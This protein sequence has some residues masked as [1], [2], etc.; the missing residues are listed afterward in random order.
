[1]AIL[2]GRL[3]VQAVLSRAELLLSSGSS[4]KGALSVVINAMGAAVD[5]WS[6]LEAEETE[7]RRK[8]AEI[9]KYKMQ[10]HVVRLGFFCW[11]ALDT[12]VLL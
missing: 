10:V 3:N 8:E 2:C 1:M 11:F 5:A 12:N 6:R 9:I 7:K 4:G